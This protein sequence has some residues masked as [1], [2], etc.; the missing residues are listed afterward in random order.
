MAENSNPAQKAL[1][2]AFLNTAQHNA[3]LIINE[4]NERLGKSDVGEGSL[5]S[6]IDNLFNPLKVKTKERK[7]AANFLVSHFP[8]LRVFISDDADVRENQ[9]DIIWKLLNN[10]L[11]RLNKER[12][13]N[14]HWREQV[15]DFSKSENATLSI[16][17]DSL[18]IRF[19][20]W[21][22]DEGSKQREIA[23]RKYPEI[24]K[25]QY[26]YIQKY[27]LLSPF[28]EDIDKPQEVFSDW[29]LIYFTCLFLEKKQANLF[30]SSIKGLKNTSNENFRAVRAFYTHHCC[31]LPQPRLESSDVL[32]DMLGE[33]RRC[34][35]LLYDL[36]S[37]NDKAYFQ[38]TITY[39]AGFDAEKVEEV[40]ISKRYDD[41]LPYF[42]LRYLDDTNALPDIRFQLYVGKVVNKK[43]EAKIIGELTDRYLLKEIHVFDKLSEYWEKKP[44]WTINNA[45]N[46]ETNPLEE[47]QMTQYSPHYNIS[48]NRVYFKVGVSKKEEEGKMNLPP[49]AVISVH[50]LSNLLLYSYLYPKNSATDK[51]SPTQIFISKYVGLYRKFVKAFQENKVEPVVLPP[52]FYK[53]RLKGKENKDMKIGKVKVDLPYTEIELAEMG[54]RR[55]RLQAKL[56]TDF[57]GLKW[58]YLPDDIKEYLLGFQQNSYHYKALFF[59]DYLKN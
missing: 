40:A 28:W 49:D 13:A 19:L 9:I 22:G 38:H 2:G 44:T 39:K 46:P 4:V 29:G 5:P 53:K 37:D 11:Q 15:I 55:M 18:K 42:I 45:P 34:P 6:A 47:G 36:L 20:A 26:K 51:T 10:S 7:F 35:A 17:L 32:L 48:G 57:K 16:D 33:L 50:E 54:E 27:S 24:G 3:Y 1:F 12:N 58:H 30:L 43:Y 25:N 14:S 52:D 23:N 56:D 41:R 21:L 31:L 59:I 8:F